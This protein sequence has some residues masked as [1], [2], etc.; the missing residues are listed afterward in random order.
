MLAFSSTVACILQHEQDPTQGRGGATHGDDGFLP[1]LLQ[2]R[3]ALRPEDFVD[4]PVDPRFVQRVQVD[5][6][7]VEQ[8]ERDEVKP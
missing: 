7:S 2:L 8:D 4:G 6:R 3:N 5:L 1:V